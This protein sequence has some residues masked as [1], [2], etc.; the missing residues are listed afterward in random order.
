MEQGIVCIC[1]YEVCIYVCMCVCQYVCLYV[2]IHIRTYVCMY[3]ACMSTYVCMCVCNNNNYYNAT[4]AE[5]NALFN[6]ALN[7]LL[8]IYMASGDGDHNY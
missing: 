4:N 7:T 2:C 8:R 5:G 1:A 3:Y 6:D